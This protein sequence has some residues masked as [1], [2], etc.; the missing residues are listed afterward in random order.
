MMGFSVTLSGIIVI[1]L[2][3][4][5]SLSMIA[6]ILLLGKTM[7]I[8][9]N[10]R[11]DSEFKK[12]TSIMYIVNATIETDNRTIHFMFSNNG[13][14]PFYQYDKFDLIVTYTTIDSNEKIT[15]DLP[16]TQRWN[17][18]TVFINGGY[19]TPFTPDTIIL[20]SMT[21]SVQALLP[22]PADPTSPI[23]IVFVNEYGGRAHYVFVRG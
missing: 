23:H 14:Q 13:S 15:V 1:S 19:S 21:A 22:V 20:P 11:G 6:S 12:I 16:Y 9:I 7:A 10:L 4:M 2:L 5:T 18:T 8:G 17:I 3:I